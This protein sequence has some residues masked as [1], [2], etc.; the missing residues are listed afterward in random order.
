MKGIIAQFIASKLEKWFASFQSNIIG[1]LQLATYNYLDDQISVR[2]FIKQIFS[3]E[4]PINFVQSV[5]KIKKK[6]PELP[7]Y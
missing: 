3:L 4:I 2:H 6:S 7:I 1:E 5:M